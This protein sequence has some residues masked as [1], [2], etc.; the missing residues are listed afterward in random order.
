MLSLDRAIDYSRYFAEVTTDIELADLLDELTREMGFAYFALTH[1]VDIRHNPD[2]AIRL[3]NYPG[4]WVEYYDAHSLGA[5]DPVHRASHVTNLAFAWSRI[6]E[7]I[8]LTDLDRSIL[9]KGGHNG[10]GDGFTVPAHIPGESHGSCT[11]ANP[12][13][14]PL[15]EEQLPIALLIGQYAFDAARRLWQ[16][17][18]REPV[19]LLTQRQKECVTWVAAGK[20]DWE[21]AQ[22][23]GIAED[24]VADHLKHARD[25]YGGGNRSTLVARTLY[26][27][28][29]S[30]PEIFRR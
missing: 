5:S 24:T 27:T 13:G 25:R 9:A 10:I 12:I 16:V 7:L 18:P 20:T 26:D 11:F 2:R 15:P 21:I 19:S 28:S 1:H 30:F 6:P 8:A 4:E 14:I 3:L 22:I 29:I 23:L 17:R